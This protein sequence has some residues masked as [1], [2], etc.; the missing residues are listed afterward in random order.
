MITRLMVRTIIVIMITTKTILIAAIT[1]TTTEIVTTT[2]MTIKTRIKIMLTTIINMITERRYKN[3][4]ND[5]DKESDN[6]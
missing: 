6:D 3:Y 2:K 4:I 1:I 5:N